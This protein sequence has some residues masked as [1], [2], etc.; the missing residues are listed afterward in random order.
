MTPGT[1]SD[2]EP[3]IENASPTASLA[4]A[5]EQEALV[6][7][8]HGLDPHHFERALFGGAREF[9]L[10]PGK[11]FRARLVETCFALT[12]DGAHRLPRA[13]LETIELLHGGS[14]IVDDIQD[15]AEERRG[16][17]ALHRTLGM[18]RALNVGNWLYFVALSKLDDVDLDPSRSLAATRAA[19]RCLVRCHEGQAL[20]LTLRIAELKR[21]EV[22]CVARTTSELKTGA[23]M[24]LAARLGA[25]VGRATQDD[26]EALSAFGERCGVVLQM[27]DDLGSFLAAERLEKGLEDLRGQR[28]NWVWAW[29]VESLDEITYKQLT[30]QTA[31]REALA[32]VRQRLA[33][34]VEARGRVAIRAALSDALHRL[35][36]RFGERPAFVGLSAELGRLEKSYG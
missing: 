6:C 10:R 31:R 29:A 34:A 21:A 19:H 25:L 24:G 22:A 30:R 26:V 7:G 5:L 15:D 1:T 17:P 9:L 35:E 23:L 27:L 33:Q 4:A 3:L 2:L 12:A 32:E 18:P 13:A 20:D 36:P 16:G 28:V 14:L 8:G 11:A